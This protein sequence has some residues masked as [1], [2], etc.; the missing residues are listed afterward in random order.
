MRCV[1]TCLALL[2]L[3]PSAVWG[4]EPTTPFDGYYVIPK[5]NSVGGI[6]AADLNGDGRNDLV[7]AESN[8]VAVV[9]ANSNETFS[10]PVSLCSGAYVYSVGVALLN[11]D[12][13]LDVVVTGEEFISVYLNDGTGQFTLDSAYTL[14]DDYESL[15]IADYDDDGDLDVIGSGYSFIGLF[16]N[17][18]DGT[19]GATVNIPCG[20]GG[21]AEV[22]SADFDGDTHVDIALAGYASDTLYILMNDGSGGF[23]TPVAYYA[24]DYPCGL[25]IA[26][27]N[28]DTYLDVVTAN[29]VGTDINVFT[30]KADGTL[31]ARVAYAM[32]LDNFDVAAGDFDE[33]GWLDLAV[34]SWDNSRLVI[35]RNNGNGTFTLD[36]WFENSS[37][38]CVLTANLDGDTHIDIVAPVGSDYL[39]IF[40]GDGAGAFPGPLTHF[41]ESGATDF[42]T[43]D[44]DDNGTVD[45]VFTNSSSHSVNVVRNH[46][47]STFGALEVTTIAGGYPDQIV[48]AD[49]TNSNGPDIVV[50]DSARDTLCILLNNG[51]G[52]F[53]IS[54]RLITGHK[55]SD[56]IAMNLDGD[57]Y[58]DLA[59]ANIDGN[60]V[61]VFVNDHDGTFTLD[62]TITVGDEPQMVAPWDFDNDSDIDL[63]VAIR[64]YPGFIQVL[65]NDGSG[66]FTAGPQI[67]IPVY[68]ADLTAVDLEGDGDEDMIATIDGDSMYVVIS[69]GDG[70]FQTPYVYRLSYYGYD[71][72]AGDVDKDGDDDILLHHGGYAYFTFIGNNGDGWLGWP[73]T[74]YADDDLA[75]VQFADMNGDTYPDIVALP[76]EYCYDSTMYIYFNQQQLIPMDVEEDDAPVMLPNTFAMGAYP[77]PFNPTQTVAFTLPQ[78]ADVRLDVY[79]VLGQKVRTLINTSLPAGDHQVVWNGQS[80][81]ARMMSTGVYFYRLSAG[82]QSQTYKTVL[83]K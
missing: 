72:V 3:I 53:T 35:M 10:T 47:D 66:S 32:G 55:P 62:T 54:E 75:G 44:I 19:L 69:D 77:N 13:Y 64:N 78:R 30:G 68:L 56:P 18:G 31:N 4:A 74:W 26:D 57:A 49:L 50:T 6:Q 46:G 41:I 39:R 17:A 37:P 36:R 43:G 11:N 73:M 9:L 27:V 8:R 7:I 40:Y 34:G 83:L 80:D 79:N 63:A 70:T 67:S 1:L 81:A 14:A 65:E 12:A 24:G 23:E 29:R 61:S 76:A 82:G 33:D 52:G 21:N 5:V 20:A 71:P 48:M 45:V 28:N 16:P 2:A 38:R 58:L 25:I 51:S 15:T 22:A 60:S 42:A 59:V